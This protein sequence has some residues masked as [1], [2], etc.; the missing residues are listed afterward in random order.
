VSDVRAP[1]G[2]RIAVVVGMAERVRAG[3]GGDEV[4]APL[5]VAA[6][7]RQSTAPP[8][9]EAGAVASGFLADRYELRRLLG[10][11]GMANVY[12]AHDH[13]LRRDVAVKVL[14]HELRAEPRE[15]QRFAREASALAAVESPH[16]VA[17]HDVVI[18]DEVFLVLRLVRGRCLAALLALEAPLSPA[19]AARIAG[20]ILDGLAALHARRLVHRDVKPSNVLVEHGDR[21]VLIDLGVAL[22]RRAPSL[23][24]A[25]VVAGTPGLMAP[26][27]ERGTRVD[28]RSDLYQVGVILLHALTGVD[29]G[30]IDAVERDR[31]TAQQPP[32]L[33]AVLARALAAAPDD[34]FPDAATMQAALLHAALRR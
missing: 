19:R 8:I 13:R 16:V 27:H 12:L 30:T 21:A 9:G 31:L 29:G 10:T 28:P 3:T 15:L 1:R 18:G 11:G 6:R 20:Q 23:T 4:T 14:H 7:V 5:T 32:A 33:A 17:I 25:D 2:G 26:E 22:D 24:P 34:R